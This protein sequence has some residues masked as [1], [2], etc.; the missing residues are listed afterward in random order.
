MLRRVQTY[1]NIVWFKIRHPNILT[2]GIHH[3]RLGTEILVQN[4]GRIKIGLGVSTQRRVTFSAIGGELTIGNYSSFNRNNIIVCRDK[5]NIGNHCAFGPN[6]VIYDHDHIFDSDG[7]KSEEYNTSS[8][9]IKDNCWIGANVSILRDTVIGE[10]CVIG[11]G[12]TVKGI[13]PPHSIVINDRKNMI[14]K[15]YAR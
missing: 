3:I 13:I 6:V 8:I 2:K 9:I 7:F 11:A 4:G 15:I 10:C 12:T 1:I 5:I 14:T